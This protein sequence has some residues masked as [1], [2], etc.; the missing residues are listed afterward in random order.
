M[1]RAI[2]FVASKAKHVLAGSP[3]R[4][5]SEIKSI[6]TEKCLPCDSYRGT[7]SM[8]R[9]TKCGCPLKKI[10]NSKNKIAWATSS[11]PEGKW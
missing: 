4:S 6:F 1:K 10:G 7:L 11:C 2:S 3:Y 5:E 9:C 8:G